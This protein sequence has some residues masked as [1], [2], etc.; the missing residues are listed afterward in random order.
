MMTEVHFYNVIKAGHLHTST[1]T[2][3]FIINLN[4]TFSYTLK[5]ENVNTLFKNLDPY[6]LDESI[7]SLRDFWTCS[8]AYFYFNVIFHRSSCKQTV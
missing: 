8:G 7:C 4:D 6:H 1:L 3:W 2:T 5:G